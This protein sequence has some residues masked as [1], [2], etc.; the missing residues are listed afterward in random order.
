MSQDPEN[1]NDGRNPRL[2]TGFAVGQQAL[3]RQLFE[4]SGGSL[5]GLTLARFAEAL[6]TSAKKH[7]AGAAA[8]P[9]ELEKYLATLHLKDLALSCACA[10]GCV[11][12]WEHFVATYRPYLRSASAAILHCSSASPAACELADS[13]FAELYGLR[14]GQRSLLHYFHGRS[15]LKT[16]LRAVLAQRHIDGLRVGKRFVELDEQQESSSAKSGA[17]PGPREQT[18]ADP[19][20]ERYLALFTRALE[21]ALALL[22]PRDS[23]RLRLYYAQELTLAEIARQFGEH[24][25]S[26]SRNLERTRREL[27]RSVEDALRKGLG[28]TNGPLTATGLRDEEISLCFEYAAGSSGEP[29][30]IDFDKLF[31]AAGK[32]TP[33]ARRPE[34]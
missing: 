23:E 20:R 19:H 30:P 1:W 32:P 3:V 21:S 7:F 12:A 17:V 10:E 9:S 25:S 24:E 29:A 16:W 15:S 18:P 2:S 31:P 28:A 8:V 26:V 34:P 13:L 14:E 4:E 11:E 27:R 22:D 6:Q 5:W 33:K